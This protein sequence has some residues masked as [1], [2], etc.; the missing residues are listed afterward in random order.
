MK[1][2]NNILRLITFSGAISFYMLAILELYKEFFIVLGIDLL[3]LI[4]WLLLDKKT[5]E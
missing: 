4:V 1:I 2:L 3:L 5:I